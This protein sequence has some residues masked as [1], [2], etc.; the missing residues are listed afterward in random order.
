MPAAETDRASLVVAVDGPSGSGKSTVSRA[1]ARALDLRYLDTGAIYRALTWWVLRGGVDP[2][3]EAAVVERARS[4]ELEISTDPAD[5]WARVGDTDVTTA[6]RQPDVTTA[7]SSVSA[8]QK[9]RT[10]L[11]TRQRDIVG[12]GGIVVE[13]RDIGVTVCPDA[14]VKIFLTASAAARAGRRARE[15]EKTR[16]ADVAA[17]QADLARRDRLDASRAASPLAEAADAV[18]LDTTTLDLDQV[19]AAAL[20]LVSRRT[21]IGIAASEPIGDPR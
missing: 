4:F 2:T 7:V 13:G 17:V 15:F 5:Q 16:D 1:V 10:Q 20:A 21:G 14:P 19:V 9:I 18:E 8:V 12:P 11:L 3:D 6:I